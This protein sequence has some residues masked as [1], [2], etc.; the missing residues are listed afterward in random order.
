MN[1]IEIQIGVRGG[2]VLD[3]TFQ[4]PEKWEEV[5]HK[6]LPSLIKLAIKP[7][8]DIDKIRE[9]LKAYGFK[10][11]L[12][13]KLFLFEMR[14]VMKLFSWLNEEWNDPRSLVPK[15]GLFKGPKD[16][17][18]GL[19]LNQLLLAGIHAQNADNFQEEGDLKNL[20]KELRSLTSTLYTP[21]GLKYSYT[22]S[23]MYS[24][25]FRL[26]PM[27]KIQAASI[28]FRAQ[29]LWLKDHFPACHSGG[30]EEGIRDFGPYG[31][32]VDL[33]GQEFGDVDK[34]N[35]TDIIYVFTKLEKLALQK[36]DNK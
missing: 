13:K 14:E 22:F 4:V 3:Y 5:S 9:V 36:R 27:W 32:V 10:K 2:S 12:T 31:L 7:M 15:L 30:G 6:Q 21:L 17:L 20:R 26:F 24:P 18:S 16:Y 1:N 33:A 11:S 28:S 23:K 25:L 35:K 34:V 29:R 19:Q 8:A